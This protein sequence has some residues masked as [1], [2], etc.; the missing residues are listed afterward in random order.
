MFL[1]CSQYTRF[2]HLKLGFGQIFSKYQL[3]FKNS[4]SEWDRIRLKGKANVCKIVHLLAQINVFQIWIICICQTR[5]LSFTLHSKMKSFCTTV[6][7]YNTMNFSFKP[8]TRDLCFTS[9]WDNCK[10]KRLSFIIF[11][12]LCSH[13]SLTSPTSKQTPLK[14][15]L[16]W[17]KPI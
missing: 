16:G 5:K 3:E 10:L 13:C 2:A 15:T 4:A 17:H 11:I 14:G 1:K 6:Y 12:E 8:E 9:L 7:L